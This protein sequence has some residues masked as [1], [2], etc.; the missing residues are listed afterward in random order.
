MTLYIDGNSSIYAGGLNQQN[1][2]DMGTGVATLVYLDGTQYV[3]VYVNQNTGSDCGVSFNSNAGGGN[4]INHF[5]AFL[6]SPD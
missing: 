3:E 5:S 1:N 6:V 2:N 4:S